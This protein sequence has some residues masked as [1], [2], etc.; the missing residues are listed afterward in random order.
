MSHKRTFCAGGKI[1]G[2]GR[3]SSLKLGTFN[4]QSPSTLFSEDKAGA[5]A[6]SALAR[7]IGAQIMSKFR[8]FLDYANERMILEPA[9]N[10]AAPFDRAYS[11]L[12]LKA[13]G[14]D[15]RIFRVTDVLENSP[16]S[17]RGLQASDIFS[18]IDGRSTAEFTLTKI[19]EMFERPVPYK[20]T[21]RRGEQTISVTLMLRKMI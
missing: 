19:N 13:E 11:G 7:N 4:I 10:F 12:S 16:A 15:Y 8:I 6:S 17:D 2:L 3:V 5:F 18:A 21:V 1:A 20:L 9:P 14:K